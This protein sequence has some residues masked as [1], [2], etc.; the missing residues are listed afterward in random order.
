MD[1]NKK[2][3]F[4]SYNKEIFVQGFAFYGLVIIFLVVKQVT[5]NIKANRN[6]FVIL[7]TYLVLASSKTKQL[8]T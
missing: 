8:D 1:F 5:S 3:L 2:V 4:T 7:V 6:F